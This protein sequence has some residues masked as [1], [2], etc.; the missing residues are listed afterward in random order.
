MEKPTSK[1]SLKSYKSCQKDIML[2][3]YNFK[4]G[5]YSIKI[6][7]RVMGLEQ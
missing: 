7:V 1:I 2:I 3:M 6:H 5:H 4:K